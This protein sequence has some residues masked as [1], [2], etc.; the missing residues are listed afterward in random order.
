MD[1]REAFR[2]KDL[3]CRKIAVRRSLKADHVRMCSHTVIQIGEVSFYDMAEIDMLKL[4]GVSRQISKDFSGMT[5][6]ILALSQYYKDHDGIQALAK[7]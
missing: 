4:A 3:M 6:T 2:Q 1:L 5:N 7:S